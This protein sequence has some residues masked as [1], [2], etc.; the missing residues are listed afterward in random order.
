MMI[1]YIR[2]NG[3]FLQKKRNMYSLCEA[4]ILLKRIN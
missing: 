4:T 3:V 2:K 1:G